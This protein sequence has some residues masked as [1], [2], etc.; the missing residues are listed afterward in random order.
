MK[1]KKS[2]K[3]NR[4]NEEY[5]VQLINCFNNLVKDSENYDKGNFE[6]IRRSSVTLRMLFY[7]SINSH[8]IL[9]QLVDTSK[10]KI[11][12]TFLIEK[13]D[14]CYFGD[15]YLV[16]KIG[17]VLDKNKI[18][19]T[20][21]PDDLTIMSTGKKISFKDWWSGKIFFMNEGTEITRHKLITVMAN[22]D[23]G[24]HVDD[25]VDSAYLNISRGNTGYSVNLSEF[26]PNEIYSK[27]DPDKNG[28]IQTK[29]LNLALMRKIVHEVLVSLPRQLQIDIDYNP[30]FSY[31]MKSNLN[32]LMFSIKVSNSK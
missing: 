10:L 18:Y 24:A 8:S 2:L 27:M 7:N 21:I 26:F 12:N 1:R 13:N 25:S 22:Q 31:N 6:S 23:G 3:I 16:Q 17:T 4:S 9:D 11:L 20:F 19:T 28:F 5:K 15:V 29:D 30:D 14:S 32:K